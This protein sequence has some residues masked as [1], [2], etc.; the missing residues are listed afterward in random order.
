MRKFISTV[1]VFLGSLTGA[2]PGLAHSVAA[3]PIYPAKNV[4]VIVPAGLGDTCD[5]LMRLIGPK[6]TAKI[7]QGWEI[8]NRPGASGHHGLTVLRQSPN[9]GY[10]LGCGQGG[11]MVIVPL[12][13]QKV[14]YDSTKDF[15]PVALVGSNFLALVVSADQ[16]FTTTEELIAHAKANPAKVSFGTNGYGGFLHF[17]T[18]LLSTQGGFTYLQVPYSSVAGAMTDMLSG[19]INAT[20]TSFAAAQPYIASG[21][22]RLL[23]ISTKQRSPDYPNTPTLS[24]AVPGFALSGWFGV[25]APRGTRKAVVTLLNREVNAALALPDVINQMKIY[26]VTARPESPDFFS[27]TIRNDFATWGKLLNDIGFKP[28]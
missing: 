2:T 11:N 24:E 15:A 7:R 8:D 4:R 13:Y 18:E 3:E 27:E 23:G 16:P 25:I 5:L 28:I 9:D 17:A 14:D 22:V 19:Q 10:T 20:L 26:G 6:I 12:A 1:V 21:K